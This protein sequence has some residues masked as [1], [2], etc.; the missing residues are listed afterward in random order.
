MV[1]R[2]ELQVRPQRLNR[3]GPAPQGQ[4]G[5]A[6]ILESDSE[7]GLQADRRA[8]RGLRVGVPP[9][10]EGQTAQRV[11]GVRHGWIQLDRLLEVVLSLVEPPQIAISCT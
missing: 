11:P 6:Q 7:L 5:A 8:I 10:I 9:L 4:E 2:L 3:I 1:V